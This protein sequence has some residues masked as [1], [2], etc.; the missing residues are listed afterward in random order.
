[1]SLRNYEIW[2]RLTDHPANP[3]IKPKRPEWIVGDPTIIPPKESPDGK[4][5]L[6]AHGILFGITHYVSLDGIHWINTYHKIDSGM[7]AF[8]FKED[9]IYYLFYEKYQN[10]ATSCI[11]VRHS[12]DLFHWSAPY[13]ILKPELPWEGKSDRKLA[14]PCLVKLEDRY[15]LYY[16]GGTVV[17]WDCLFFEPKYIGVAEAESIKGPY[18]K[19]QKPIISPSKEHPFRN[20]AA[21]GIKVIKTRDSWLG[22]NNGIYKENGFRSRSSILLLKSDDG[23]RWDDALPRPILYPCGTGWKRSF[24]YQLDI[25]KVNDTYWIYYNARDGWALGWEGIGLAQL[26]M[27]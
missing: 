7:R 19:R 9:E 20:Y 27:K 11:V 23:L 22:F 26:K 16:S 1:M 4:W 10:I 25:R 24:V 2:Q 15:R 5:H 3:L 13:K 14:C 12:T 18:K 6:F 17:L 8:L 21:G